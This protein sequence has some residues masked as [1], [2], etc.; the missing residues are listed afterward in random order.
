[1]PAKFSTWRVIIGECKQCKAVWAYEGWDDG[2]RCKDFKSDFNFTSF[3]GYPAFTLKYQ[4]PVW[5]NE[6]SSFSDIE[7]EQ[8]TFLKD[9]DIYI[10]RYQ[11]VPEMY[12]KYHDTYAKMVNSITI[13]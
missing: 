12:D 10:I 13:G 9:N 2:K 4:C 5:I 3:Q 7:S 11:A 8:I 1:M 6:R